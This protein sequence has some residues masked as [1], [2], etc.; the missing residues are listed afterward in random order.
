[1]SNHRAVVLLDGAFDDRYPDFYAESCARDNPYIVCADGALRAVAALAPDVAPQLVVGDMD[2]LGDVDRNAWERRGT[3]FDPTWD[4][5]TAKDCTDGQLA[6]YAALETDARRIDIHGA[7]P[8]RDA[9]D[10]DHFLGNLSLLAEAHGRLGDAPDAAVRIAEPRETIALCRS[11]LT[12]T[13]QGAGLNRVSLV[14]FGASARVARS[15]GLRWDLAG[16][17][18]NAAPANA[19]R[20]EF[21]WNARTAT[22]ELVD[23]SAPVYVFHNWYGQ[24]IQA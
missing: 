1:M 11:R 6:L 24:D 19:L 4:G 21:E 14:P 16:L 2:S 13:R 12:L 3:R 10:H 9:Y 8:R 20:N 7:L 17:Q 22:I 23:G 18:V 15:E 5:Q